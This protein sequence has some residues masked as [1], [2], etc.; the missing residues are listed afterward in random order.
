[1]SLLKLNYLRNLN[2]IIFLPFQKTISLPPLSNLVEMQT[3]PVSAKE[4]LG[5]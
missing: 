1:M 5:T 2:V 3:V 4:I